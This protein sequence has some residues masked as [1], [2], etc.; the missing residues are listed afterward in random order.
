MA[1]SREVSTMIKQGFLS[2]P[3]L[4]FSSSPSRIPSTPLSRVL[5]ASP[6][7]KTLQSPPPHYATNSPTES[8]TR[9]HHHHHHHQSHP[10]LFQMMSEE[11]PF[12][13]TRQKNYSKVSKIVQEFASLN[14][15]EGYGVG[16]VRLTVVGRDGY[17][18]S[19][20]VHKRILLEKSGFFRETLKGR[21]KGVMQSV[22]IS[23]CDDVEVYLETIVLMYCDNLRKRL[24]GE[25]VAKVLD[26]LKV[27]AAIMF[28]E[29]IMSCL[30]YLDA[31]PW[32]EDEEEK[33]I[34]N[35]S[36][37]Q[38][39]NSANEVL[40]RV[41]SEVS[42]SIRTDDVFLKLLSGILQAKDDKARREMKMLISRLFKEDSYAHDSKLDVTKDTLYSLC[43]RCLSSLVLCLSEVT[44]LD[45]SRRDR[46]ALMGEIAREAE[47]M[48]WIVEILIDKKMC[49]E[50]VMLWA[51]QR[52]L[53]V[54]HSNIPIMYRHE[55]SKITAQLCIAVGRGQILVPKETRFSLLSTWLEALYEDF[56]WMRRASRSVDKKLVEEGLGQT[57]LTL[58]LQQ[59]Q[60]IFLSWFDRFL[61]KGD[62]CPNIQ[63]AF[64]VWW[65]RTFIRKCVTEQDSSQLQIAVCDYT[66]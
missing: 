2:D 25:E 36:L 60:S 22:E 31:I 19:V 40:Q 43:H 32:S 64:E 54:L 17:R 42:S 39:H 34:S 58:P 49:D 29:G 23:E 11:Q 16:D 7:S 38:L 66:N 41:S 13:Q 9:H 62:D 18:V 37:L 65:R 45:D 59:Q 26:L 27:S 5:A 33:I 35:I 15:C 3:S 53:A 20:D 50:F 28:E 21:E 51:D 1:A 55:I 12:E 6:N 46:G 14:G 8:S 61:S 63:R 56:G 30:E 57:I 10:T 47:N 44:S 4:S 24:I 52:E 48:Q